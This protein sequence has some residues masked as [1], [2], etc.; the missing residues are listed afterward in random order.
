MVWTTCHVAEIIQGYIQQGGESSAGHPP[1]V[2]EAGKELSVLVM[3]Q[4][5]L[6]KDITQSD[7]EVDKTYTKSCKR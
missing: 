4:R 5:P 6:Y 1:N 7:I 2:R 3:S